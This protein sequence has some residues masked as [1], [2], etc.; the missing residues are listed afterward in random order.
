MIRLSRFAA[1]ALAL[2][3]AFAAV[4]ARAAPALWAASDRDSTVYLFGTAH[5]ARPNSKWR[6]REL[7]A[8]LE[9]S[10]ALWLEVRTDG[11]REAAA[12]VIQK[13]GLD[14]SRALESRLPPALKAKL[15][16]V[17]AL[18]GVP[19]ERLS[20]MRL[21]LAAVT[22]SRLPLARAGLDPKAGADLSLRTSAAA[23]GD[24]IEGFD[25]PEEQVRYLADL[26]EDEQ[27]AFLEN[28][29]DRAARG[30]DLPSRIADAWESGD[31]AAIDSILNAELKA[32]MPS[33]YRRLLVERNR[34]Y[35]GRIEALLAGKEDQFV[36]IGIGH[37]VGADGIPALLERKGVKLRRIH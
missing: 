23:E 30:A 14:P 34:R 21:W 16:A 24:R 35:A 20:P 33:L 9:S 2:A 36:A 12:A 25:T 7:D 11:H 18:Y 13:L 5:V 15:D 22:L 3:A 8:A 19:A 10:T 1:P 6:T 26:P 31:V 4:P 32:K 28:V 17:L 37:L 29:V 27:L